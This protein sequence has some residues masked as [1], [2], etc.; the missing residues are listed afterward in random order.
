M[1]SIYSLLFT[2]K[3]IRK[4]PS[5]AVTISTLQVIKLTDSLKQSSAQ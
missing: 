4:F 2:N 3:K 1:Q 5:Y